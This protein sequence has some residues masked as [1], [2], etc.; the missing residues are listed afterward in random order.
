MQ[1]FS[2][3][4]A[5]APILLKGQP[6]PLLTTPMTMGFGLLLAVV[7]RFLAVESFLRSVLS[8]SSSFQLLG[9]F[10]VLTGVVNSYCAGLTAFT[11]SNLGIPV[12]FYYPSEKDVEH[13]SP[14]ARQLIDQIAMMLRRL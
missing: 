14:A 11:R 6:S 4:S 2:D 1:K 8:F 5:K 9:I 3:P 10:V 12:P 13:I 7:F